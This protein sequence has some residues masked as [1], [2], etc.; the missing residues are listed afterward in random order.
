MLRSQRRVRAALTDAFS[1]EDGDS[2]L[3]R[4]VKK[5]KLVGSASFRSQPA[6]SSF[7]EELAKLKE[8][9]GGDVSEC[10]ARRVFALNSDAIWAICSCRGWCRLLGPANACTDQCEDRQNWFVIKE[11]AHT[12]ELME[13][14]AVFQQIDVEEATDFGSGTTTLRMFGVTQVRVAYTGHVRY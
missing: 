12:G 11:Y 8:G 4:A 5:R 10:I 3:E 6:Q 1:R 2:E 9:E 14:S 13:H 7:A